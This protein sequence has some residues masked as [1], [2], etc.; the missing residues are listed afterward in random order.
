[1]QYLDGL[2]NRAL[3]NHEG[4]PGIGAAGK[5][6][7][8]L[9]FAQ[10]LRGRVR[11]SLLREALFPTSETKARSGSIS[12]SAMQLSS[13]RKSGVRDVLSTASENLLAE[14]EISSKETP[15]CSNSPHTRR[16]LG[17]QRRP[18]GV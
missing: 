4:K 13:W 5:R 12:I 11:F 14:G 6:G 2:G 3:R 17:G 9:G 1:M 8:S 15:A 18:R 7:S 10:A 16:Q